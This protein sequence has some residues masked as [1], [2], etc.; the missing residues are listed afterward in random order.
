METHLRCLM[1]SYKREY[2]GIETDIYLG[3][4]SLI[5]IIMCFEMRENKRSYTKIEW[6]KKCHYYYLLNTNKDSIID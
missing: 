1:P 5:H 4:H 6:Y 3:Y 2:T